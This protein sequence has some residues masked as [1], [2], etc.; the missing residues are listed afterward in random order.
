MGDI[1]DSNIKQYYRPHLDVAYNDG[2]NLD[3]FGRLRVSGNYTIFDS[4]N[5]NDDV[6]SL[7]YDKVT[8]GGSI[9]Y[10]QTESSRILSVT[11]STGSYAIVQTKRSFNYQPGK[12]Q[13]GLFTGIL[14]TEVGVTKRIGMFDS[15]TGGTFQPNN[16]LFIENNGTDVSVNIVKNTNIT[17]IKQSDW[18]IDKF[19]GTN[20][21]E[22]PSGILL[23]FTKSQIFI[24]DFEWLGVGRIRYGF[25]INGITYYCHEVLNANNIEGVYMAYPNLPIRYE[26]RSTGGVGTLRQICSMVSSEGGFEPNGILRSI[27][28]SLIAGM[29]IAADITR[30]VLA[31]RLKT[32]NINAEIIPQTVS[33][34][35]NGNGNFFWALKFYNGNETIS[36][37]G[38]P[39]QWNDMVFTGLTNSNIE[40]KN[41]FLTTDIPIVGQGIE[42]G[43]GLSALQG[44]GSLYTELLNA[45]LLGSKINGVKDVLV[46]ELTNIG[47]SDTYWAGLSW[48]EV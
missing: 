47:T 1:S 20:G 42:I 40:F 14:S 33:A 21:N 24:I 29:T 44:G 17:S 15:L 3:A 11:G 28:T 23:N 16:G 18:N 9:T 38:T 26:I 35:N 27:R 13:I 37:N 22:N 41:N 6:N 4:K 31:I 48:R 19:D 46:L 36:R 10:L 5:L 32:N 25:N 7:H 2:A 8:S 43:N 45:L 12:S 30:P 34:A 39:T